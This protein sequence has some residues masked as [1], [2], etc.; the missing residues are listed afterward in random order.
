M[1]CIGA[2]ISNS[3]MGRRGWSRRKSERRVLPNGA[4]S[5]IMSVPARAMRTTRGIPSMLRE[6]RTLPVGENSTTR[7][8]RAMSSTCTT[9][10]P[11]TIA[12]GFRSLPGPDPSRPNAR[13]SWPPS[14]RKTWT[15]GAGAVR[16]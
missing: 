13:Y 3:M 8:D 1:T 11:A 7:E 10:A 14:I 6:A 9:S 16:T 5:P 12:S 15:A 4:A 2:G